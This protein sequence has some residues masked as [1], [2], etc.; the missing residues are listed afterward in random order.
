MVKVPC[1]NCHKNLRP[2]KI[3]KKIQAK[4]YCKDCYNKL[5]PP[6]LSEPKYYTNKEL[7]K[8]YEEKCYIDKKTGYYK[9]KATKKFVHKWVMEEMMGRKLRNQEVVHHLNGNKLDNCSSNLMLF[10]NQTEH[11]FW[12]VEQRNKSGV[13]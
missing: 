8:I 7:E 6:K 9:F 11:F 12:H 3:Y 1:G 10:K 5:F 2:S 4:P 13:W